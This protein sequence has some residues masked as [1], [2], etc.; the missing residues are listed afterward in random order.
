MELSAVSLNWESLGYSER[1]R[2]V[3]AKK[4]Y[5][6]KKACKKAPYEFYEL[7]ARFNIGVAYFHRAYY[8]KAVQEFN[9][10]IWQ[11][12]KWDKDK[13]S[14][15]KKEK[16][17]AQA[18]LIFFEKNLGIALLYIL[19]QFSRSEVQLKLQMAYHTL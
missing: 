15:K 4:K 17:E 12:E 5:S 1:A 18:C 16:D 9:Q 2:R 8:Q 11:I 3:I 10:I 19:S 13:N 6:L 14:K 7:W